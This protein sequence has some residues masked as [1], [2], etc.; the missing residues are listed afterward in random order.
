M[1]ETQP[2]VGE[3]LEIPRMSRA[4]GRRIGIVAAVVVLGAGLAAFFSLRGP[5]V[6]PYR[7]APVTKSSIVKEVRVTGSVELTD[8][9]E[10]PA[11]IEGQLVELLVRPG[12]EVEKGQPLGRL[13]EVSAE[14]ALTVARA[15]SQV[16]RA[17]VAD[18]EASVRRAGRALERTQRLA[19]KG[20]TSADASAIRRKSWLPARVWSSRCRRTRGWSWDHGHGSFASGRP[21]TSC[22]SRLR[23]ARL[24]S[25]RCG[26]A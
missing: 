24:T 22:G 12:D 6:S 14:V 21:W 20:L 4:R 2:T 11:P 25:A 5:E 18:A 7:A 17:S 23:S 13:D 26:S 3:A 1:Q 8:Q 9:V 10:I 19:A 15:E 16:A